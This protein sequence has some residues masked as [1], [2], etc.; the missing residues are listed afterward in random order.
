MA[1]I[2]STVPRYFW[3]SLPPHIQMRAAA[4][5]VP[6]YPTFYLHINKLTGQ[7]LKVNWPFFAGE[8]S[9]SV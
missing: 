6:I 3:Q 2:F 8:I 5:I 1:A 9:C 7:A 4:G